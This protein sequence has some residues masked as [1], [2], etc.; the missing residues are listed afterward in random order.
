[1]KEREMIWVHWLIGRGL[2]CFA[3]Y[4]I[5][6]VYKSSNLRRISFKR[7][8]VSR[9]G[10]CSMLLTGV[11]LSG[12]SLCLQSTQT[13][14]C[15]SRPVDGSHPYRMSYGELWNYI[16]EYE[17]PNV[18]T[19]LPRELQGNQVSIVVT[20]DEQGRLTSCTGLRLKTKALQKALTRSLENKSTEALCSSMRTWKFRPLVYCGN[21]V[22][23]FGPIL[24]NVR[25]QRFEL[26]EVT[27]PRWKTSAAPVKRESTH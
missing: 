18:P 9:L 11:S 22:P 1:L 21:P 8:I 27:D 14:V 12:L 7:S 20:L 15:G 2:V 4:G 3:T 23:V 19:E 16:Q 17:D 10:L 24:F 13:P 5:F 6:L 26:V 25:K